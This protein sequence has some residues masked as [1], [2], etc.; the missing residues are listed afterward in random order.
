VPR[1]Q[2]HSADRILDA[3]RELVLEGGARAATVDGVVARSGA[4]K[5]S[6][7]HRYAT[8][9]DLL[10]AMWLRAVERSQGSF[11]AALGDDD[12]V[13]AAVAGALAIH[14]FAISDPADARL[15]ASLRREDLLGSVTDPDLVQ[16]LQDVNAPLRDGVVDLARRLYGRASRAS[17]ERTTFA[18]IDL[19]HGAI[20]RHLIAGAK[21][22][23]GLRAQVEAAVRAAVGP[24]LP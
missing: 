23:A 18:V 13:E 21:L 24:V 1:P 6:I 17:V 5:G 4:P 14:D 8:L 10:A 22:P 20:R 19:A 3:A 7:Y 2:L 9:N 16:S 15:L 11:L 12:P